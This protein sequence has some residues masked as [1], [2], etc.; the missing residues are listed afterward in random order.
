M[1]L[2]EV[3]SKDLENYSRERLQEPEVEASAKGGF[4]AKNGQWEG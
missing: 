2:R 4:G 3:L 1:G